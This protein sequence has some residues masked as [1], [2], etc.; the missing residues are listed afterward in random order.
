MNFRKVS[1]VQKSWFFL[2]GLAMGTLLMASIR[3]MAAQASHTGP[4]ACPAATKAPGELSITTL[5]TPDR[6][7]PTVMILLQTPLALSESEPGA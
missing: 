4:V 1:K 3:D 5:V 6:Q 7:T 2:Q